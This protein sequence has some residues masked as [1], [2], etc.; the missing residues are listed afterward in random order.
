[1]S[2]TLTLTFRSSDLLPVGLQQHCLTDSYFTTVTK[3][4]A[5]F[6]LGAIL[7]DTTVYICI[8][9]VCV[10][11]AVCRQCWTV[12]DTT[13]TPT[14]ISSTIRTSSTSGSRLMD[15]PDWLVFALSPLTADER[16]E[17]LFPTSTNKSGTIC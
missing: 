12:C 4:R 15:V 11:C 9:D 7:P 17:D 14:R 8:I 2:L 16:P 13:P 5:I 3:K 6:Q 1:M 10:D